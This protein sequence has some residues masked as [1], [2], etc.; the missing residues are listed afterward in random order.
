MRSLFRAALI[1]C[2]FFFAVAAL[3]EGAEKRDD[4]AKPSKSPALTTGCKALDDLMTAFNSRDSL[5]W[6]QTLNYP[7]VRLSGNEVIVWNTPEDY[8]KTND[9][10]QFAKATGWHHS[11]WAWRQLVQT[12]DDKLHFLVEFT[13][14]NEAG[15]PTASYESLYIITKVKN[16]WGVQA[17]SSFAGVAIP[18]SAF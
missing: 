8:A 14:Y 12:S 18:G 1:L 7:H 11:R 3:A 15:K 6:A 13:R 16:R 5:Q 2:V 10:Q 17:R 4:C 9:L